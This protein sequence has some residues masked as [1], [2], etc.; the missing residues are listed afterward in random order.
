MLDDV[1]RQ[2]L[3]EIDAWFHD[4]DPRL[5]RR[6]TPDQPIWSRRPAA[7]IASIVLVLIAAV[8]GGLAL[9]GPPAG[10]EAGLIV[11]AVATGCWLQSR[12]PRDTP[13]APR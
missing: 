9:A 2:R 5:A 10:I 12:R 1:E 6:F 3:S 4:S 13:P 7:A 11:A 8:F